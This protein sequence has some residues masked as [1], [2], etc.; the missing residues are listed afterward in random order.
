MA[1]TDPWAAHVCRFRIT[2][3]QVTATTA[4]TLLVR[5]GLDLTVEEG[6][7]ENL[8]DDEAGQPAPSSLRYDCTVRLTDAGNLE[9]W[10]GTE[11][12]VVI[13]GSHENGWRITIAGLGAV[14]YADPGGLEINFEKSP[15]MS[16][17]EAP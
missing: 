1:E 8:E 15:R 5:H 12:Q 17:H 4:E 3:A 6:R 16:I 11:M 7:Y 9:S 2:Q 10:S 14:G 13:T